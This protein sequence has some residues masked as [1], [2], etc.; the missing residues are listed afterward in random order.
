M[1]DFKSAFKKV[2]ELIEDLKQNEKKYL[3]PEYQEAEVKRDFIDKQ[4]DFEVYKLTEEE[5]K[6]VEWTQYVG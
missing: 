1:T 3:S 6:I 2:N 5:I 4:I